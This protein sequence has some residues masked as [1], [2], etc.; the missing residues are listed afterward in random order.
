MITVI[1]GGFLNHSIQKD[2]GL[3][4]VLA[5]NVKFLQEGQQE[6]NKEYDRQY[7]NRHETGALI[8]DATL[9]RPS[10]YH[11][12]D[13]PSNFIISPI[14]ALTYHLHLF[15]KEGK[16]I[17]PNK[18]LSEEELRK[19]ER[20][21]RGWGFYS[22]GKSMEKSLSKRSE[23]ASVKNIKYAS[24]LTFNMLLMA[25]V[26]QFCFHF[27]SSWRYAFL[28]GAGM[29][30][31]L[32]ITQVVLICLLVIMLT[33]DFHLYGDLAAKKTVVACL[34][35]AALS[36]AQAML[37]VKYIDKERFASKFVNYGVYTLLIVPI[38]TA[39]HCINLTLV[40]WLYKF[41][42]FG[43]IG[44]EVMG[45]WAAIIVTMVYFFIKWV[46]AKR[47]RAYLEG[48]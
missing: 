47:E 33:A 25:L 17:D 43:S 20:S 26:L 13:F 31:L 39:L 29:S 15:L 42:P 32:T 36:K 3:S 12:K 45:I 21:N 9:G 38:F 16:I 6:F 5:V 10:L 40:D 34:I 18:P 35:F 44:V 28:Q 37:F 1:G 46:M 27:I 24:K 19:I 14:G 8:F 41:S 30:W 11:F 4:E 48:V 23:Y 22:F 7:E 2:M